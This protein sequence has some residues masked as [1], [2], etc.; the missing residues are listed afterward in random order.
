MANKR[1]PNRTPTEK[2]EDG[3][4]D[5]PLDQQVRMLETLA[6]LHRHKKRMMPTL[7][8]Q[9]GDEAEAAGRAAHAAVVGPRTLLLDVPAP[10][11]GAYREE[12]KQ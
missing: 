2:I 5:L 8:P 10:P 6:S 1:Q 11:D 9:T 3:F 7:V 12:R 4:M